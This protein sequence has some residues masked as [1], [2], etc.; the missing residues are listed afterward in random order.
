MKAL[1]G[2]RTGTGF[3]FDLIKRESAGET[4]WMLKRA[5]KLCKHDVLDSSAKDSTKQGLWEH[6]CFRIRSIY[7]FLCRPLGQEVTVPQ[8]IDFD[9]LNVV[10][11]CNVHLRIERRS[12]LVRSL[13][14]RS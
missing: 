7:H 13:G 12:Y 3:I 9:I 5:I 2:L 6:Q 10:T 1:K 11:I 14:S 8:V 4:K